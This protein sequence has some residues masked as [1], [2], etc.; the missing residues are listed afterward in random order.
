MKIE[1]LDWDSNF[2]G[3]RIGRVEIR[4]R[5]E[6][7]FITSQESQIRKDYDLLYV[8]A[9]HGLTFSA[10]KA[11]MMDEKVIYSLSTFSN[12]IIDKN[13]ISWSENQGVPY[14]LLHLALVSGKYSRFKLDD[15]LPNGSYERLYSQWIEQSVNHA[16]ASEV[17]C[18]MIEGV[19]K[20]LVTLNHKNGIGDIGLVAVHE[21]YQHRGIGTSMMRNAI[22]YSK[23]K[24][25]QKLSVV[26][27]HANT[28][29]CNLYEKSGFSVESVIDVWHWWL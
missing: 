25:L 21:D 15:R 8:F 10:P 3:L 17:F 16:I 13:I 23:E 4:N 29:A 20:G 7:A 24:R 6:N 18:Y 9:N 11:R 22:R 14:E 27:Q 5:E 28:P 2:F 19:P 26:T 1:K 12:T